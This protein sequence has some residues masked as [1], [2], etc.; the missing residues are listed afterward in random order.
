MNRTVINGLLFICWIAI[1]A[2]MIL[3]V[4]PGWLAFVVMGVLIAIGMW[5]NAPNSRLT[6]GGMMFGFGKKRSY[7]EIIQSIERKR[8]EKGDAAL[9]NAERRLYEGHVFEAY[10]YH[11]GGFDYYLAHTDSVERW[12]QANSA[13][14]AIG[15][16]ADL[17]PLFHEAVKLYLAHVESDADEEATKAY[18]GKIR[19]VDARFRAALPDLDAPLQKLAR[20]V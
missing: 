8:R 4:V 10:F 20:T 9:T 7:D 6:E 2:L 12:A 17:S 16:D 11:Q 15:R 13:L 3:R 5:A 14:M 19:E 1:I 18:L